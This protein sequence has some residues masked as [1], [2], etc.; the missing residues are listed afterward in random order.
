MRLIHV[1]SWVVLAAVSC[2]SI[3]A[4]DEPT[5]ETLNAEYEQAYEAWFRPWREAAIAGDEA[6]VADLEAEK[7]ERRFLARFQAGAKR[8]R[9]TEQ[10]VPWLNWVLSHGRYG[11][12]GAEE[13]L[14]ILLQE[15]VSSPALG[16]VPLIVMLMVDREGYDAATAR[17]H[18]ARLAE[19]NPAPEI[20]AKAFF[21]SGDIVVRVGGDTRAAIEDLRRASELTADTQLVQRAQAD[22]WDLEHLQVGMTAP[23][24]E[25]EDLEGRPLRL[26]TFRGKVVLLDFWGHW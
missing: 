13:A 24:I 15:H 16:S 7:P 4:Q 17:S 23:E 10:A 2:G 20:K 18:L 14:A 19:G 6:R 25:G 22:I 21:Y 3:R 1:M 12:G 26:S 5:F 11:V 8:H 9:G